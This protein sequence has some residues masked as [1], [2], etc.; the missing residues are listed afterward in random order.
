[1]RHRDG[2]RSHVTG[3]P[4]RARVGGKA[5][6]FAADLMRQFL[7]LIDVR[8]EADQPPAHGD[9][10]GIEDWAQRLAPIFTTLNADPT[11]HEYKIFPSRTGP[12]P[13]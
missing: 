6:V 2:R 9:E 8:V 11:L 13:A 3:R 10:Q 4:R 12:Y 7:K 5:A 1:M